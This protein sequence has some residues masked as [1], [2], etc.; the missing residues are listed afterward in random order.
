MIRLED[1][2]SPK[3]KVIFV[4]L[5]YSYG[6]EKRGHGFEWQMY[7]AMQEMEDVEVIRYPLELM[8][9]PPEKKRVANLHLLHLVEAWKPDF[10]FVALF[11]DQLL[12]EVLD[13]IKKKTC[14]LGFCFDSAW[15]FESYEKAVAPHFTYMVITNA[16][17]ISRYKE[18]SLS[19][20]KATYGCRTSFFKPLNLPKIYDISFIGG[21]HGNRTEVIRALRAKG[22]KVQVFGIGWP[23][24]V[25]VPYEEVVRVFNQSKINLNLANASTGGYQQVKGRH[26]E[27]PGCKAFQLSSNIPEL[28]EYFYPN[29]EIGVFNSDV[30]LYE[31]CIY[32]LTREKEREEI[33][34]RAYKKTLAEHTWEI[35]FREIFKA[36]EGKPDWLL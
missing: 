20:I 8:Q 22:L 11:T 17:S 34:E 36:A 10:V 14:L 3:T 28:Y 27:I 35:R 25:E 29:R 26:F 33:A 13:E 1:G 30:D 16:I 2:P 31:K 7:L 15:R 32:Y 23:D 12:P 21:N 9:T 19:F 24:T 18:S 6:E 5:D 4:A